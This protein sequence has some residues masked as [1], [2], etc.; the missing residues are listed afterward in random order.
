MAIYPYGRKVWSLDGASLTGAGSTSS[1]V[2]D[3]HDVTD[4]WLA[5]FVA[6]APSGTTPTL[7]V[8]IDL[9]DQDSNVYPAALALTAL[10]A[11]GHQSGSCGLHTSNLVLPMQCQVTW[12]LGGTNPVFTGATLSLYGR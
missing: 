2:L 7:T 10:T 5:A 6:N 11:A 4:L 8:Q 3:I 9:L 1:A 12:T